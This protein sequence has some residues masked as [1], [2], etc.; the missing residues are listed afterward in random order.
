MTFDDDQINKIIN[1]YKKTR[2][3]ER[4][5]YHEVKKTNED[6]V[7]KNRERARNHYETN[8]EK[9]KEEYV[10]KKDFYKCKSLFYY[11]KRNDKRD[12]FMEKFPEKVE[13]LN[14]NHFKF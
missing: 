3:R 8:K 4:K 9:K 5:Y 13:I 11:Y 14:Q 7:N 10:D 2:E 6:F 12:V 1:Q